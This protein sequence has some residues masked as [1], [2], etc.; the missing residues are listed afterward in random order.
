M[1][2]DLLKVLLCRKANKSSGGS[3]WLGHSLCVGTVCASLTVG[4][5]L[6]QIM[7]YGLW[8]FLPVI[9]GYLEH[10]DTISPDTS[11]WLFFG[12]M[13]SPAPPPHTS[14]FVNFQDALVLRQAPLPSVSPPV[15]LCDALETLLEIDE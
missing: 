1:V 3:A 4:V 2:G 7:H 13:T 6:M 12:W 5:P 15:D 14:L 11:V 8:K 10:F 9:Q